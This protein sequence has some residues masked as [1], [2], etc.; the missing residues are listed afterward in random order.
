[1]ENKIILKIKGMHCASCAMKIEQALK[2]AKGVRNVNVNFASEKATVEIEPQYINEEKI[3][4]I[5]SDVGYDV[6]D[7]V[8]ETQDRY[9]DKTQGGEESKEVVEAKKAKKRLFWAWGF[10]IP[11]IFIMILGMFFKIYIPFSEWIIFVLAAP[12]IFWTGSKTYQSA[13]KSIM[14]FSA[15]M[16]VLIFLGTFVA[17]LT[18]P[19]KII[20]PLESYAGVAA[21]IMSFHLTGKYL[22]AKAKGKTS[23]AIRKLLQ[24]GAKTARVRRGEKEIDV[25]IEE[26]K[27]GDIMIVRPGEK[28]PTDGLIIKGESAIDESMA[29]GESMPQNKK[30]GDE[31]IGATINKQGLL[32]V[33]AT[34]VGKDTFL[35][36]IIKMVEEAQGSKVPI[37]E[38]ADRVTSVFV[39]A[40][41]ILSVL[42]FVLWNIFPE[43]FVSILKWIDAFIPWV[44]PNLGI[45]SLAIY[46]TVAVLVIACPCA[47][48]LATP[49]ALMVGSG[50]GAENGVLIRSG[51]AIQTLKDIHTI[52]FDKTGTV[53]KGEPEVT[54]II[55]A[56]SLQTTD[57]SK[58]ELLYLAGS[59]ETGSE[60]SLAES[61]IKKAK[62][63]EV[64]LT[65][66]DNFQA[67]TGKGAKGTVSGKEIIIGNQ[68]LMEDYKADYSSFEKDLDK[69]EKEGK[70]TMLVAEKDNELYKVLGVMAVADTLKKD[71]RRAI[72]K[73]NDMGYET[74]IITGD[75]KR[76]GRAIAG[77]VGIDKVLADVL[78]GGKVEEIKR[79]Q[80]KVGKVAMVGDGI[81]DAPALKQANVGIAI[82]TGTDIAIESSDVTLVSGDLMSVV[83]AMKLSKATFKKIK[84]NLF[85]AFFYNIVAIPIAFFGLLHPVIAEVAMAASSINVVTNSLRLKKI[86]L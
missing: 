21:M 33:K 20:I 44:N 77:L 5:I 23:S 48:G 14:R 54:D 6:V 15:N 7:E 26:V 59:L 71:A 17:Y 9:F 52:V 75:N 40:V 66:V 81:N 3:K 46:A 65:E 69:L 22:E 10:T 43:F 60:H 35:S 38:F 18:F 56:N 79:L 78:P 82:G 28:I 64:A 19:L 74:I 47:L 50:I 34:K 67:I 24:L 27:V 12:V 29:T 80:G 61:V 85:W 4:K 32:E 68:S 2:N 25:P 58:R 31:I 62:K 36:Q 11:I 16:D 57:D 8:R 39:P 63:E 37:Q 51:E 13:L 42:T 30:T 70:T 49:T 1:M 45:I 84:Q 73:L 72:A 86:K 53:T 76:T 83:K 55:T 41:L